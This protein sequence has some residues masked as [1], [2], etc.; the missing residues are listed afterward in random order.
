MKITINTEL[1][2]IEILESISIVELLAQI[3]DKWKTFKIVKP[4]PVIQIKEIEKVTIPPFDLLP[5]WNTQPYIPS[6][7]YYLTETKL[8]GTK[9]VQC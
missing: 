4:T 1:E 7:P 2:T 9:E 8:H 3:P 6:Q 5:P